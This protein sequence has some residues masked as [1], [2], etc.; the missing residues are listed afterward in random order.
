VTV[1]SVEA[2]SRGDIH[3]GTP[4]SVRALV[5]LGDLAPAEVAVQL[6]LGRLN[7]DGEI[8]EAAAIPMVHAGQA[9][10]NGTQVFEAKNV[11]CHRSGRI[12]YTVRVLPFHADEARVFLPGL[13]RWASDQ[14]VK[15]SVA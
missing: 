13:I 14:M 10:D 9:P 15:T 3:V 6:Y 8:V 2:I 5:R 7:A 4:I 11:L 12:G 1:E